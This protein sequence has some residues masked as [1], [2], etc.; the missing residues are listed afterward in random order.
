MF[1]G[2]ADLPARVRRTFVSIVLWTAMAP[3]VSAAPLT[4]DQAWQRAE[5]ANPALQSAQANLSAA[6]GQLTDARGL[7]WNNP[8]L[9]AD[10][11][12]RRVPQTGLDDRSRREGGAG[13][14]QTFEIAGQQGY[15]REAATKELA[16]LRSSLEETRRQ[17]RAA[18]EQRFVRVLALQLRIATE[19]EALKLVED[20]AAAVKKR[21]TAG[22][23]SRLDGNLAGIEAERTRNQLVALREQLTEARAEL[24]SALQLPSEALPEV[25]GDLAPAA[26]NY[27]LDQLLV[28]AGERPLVRSLELREAAAKNRLD[29]ERALAYPDITVGLSASSEASAEARD[30]L[31]GLSVSIPLPLF[32][33]NATGIG[34]ATTELTQAQIDR[35]VAGRDTPAQVRALWLKVESLRTRVKRLEETVLATLDENQRL[36]ATSYRAGEIG[37]LQLIVVNRQV[38]DGR[39][40]LLDA[41]T[42]LRLATVAL[43]ASAG[44]PYAGGGK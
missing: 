29:L 20:A 27:S 26:V 34:R 3:A 25:T 35:Q 10:G 38:L 31:V 33:R 16:A 11:V 43:R 28:S 17:V 41:R 22:Q 37:L 7:L 2:Y 4:L 19:Q 21:V 14:S 15:R 9:S 5:A 8:Q 1:F 32:R 24:A 39:R 12:R 44:W 13:I 36:S 30:K 40:D 18:V 42:E 23:D 6:E